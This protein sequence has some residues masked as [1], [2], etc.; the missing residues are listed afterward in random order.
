MTEKK[1]DGEQPAKAS[2]RINTEFNIWSIAATLVTVGGLFAYVQS[3]IKALQ[4]ED[5]RQ[6]REISRVET[7]TK[8]RLDQ[9]DERGTRDREAVLTMQGDIRIIRHILEGVT[10]PPPR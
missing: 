8:R 9:A 2:L 1:D 6:T 4:V 3:D 5:L 10:R 7:E